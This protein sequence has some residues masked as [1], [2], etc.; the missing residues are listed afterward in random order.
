MRE[1]SKILKPSRAAFSVEE[2]AEM[3]GI[4]RT[5]AFT[6]IKNGKIKTIKLGKRRLVTQKALDDF[7]ASELA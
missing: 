3:I 2:F 1:E 7:L 5:Y 6:L 4:G